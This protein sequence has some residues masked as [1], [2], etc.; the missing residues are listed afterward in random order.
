LVFALCA[1][2]LL[3]WLLLEFCTLDEDRDREEGSI[4]LSFNGGYRII[5]ERD[6]NL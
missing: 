4:L 1:G 3:L 6:W 5:D 2:L